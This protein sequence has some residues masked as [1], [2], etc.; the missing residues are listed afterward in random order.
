[1]L[2]IVDGSNPLASLNNSLACRYNADL[3]WVLI[4]AILAGVWAVDLVALHL[5]AA[6]I[7]VV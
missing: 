4:A 6:R 3:I 1:M 5:K 7:A 2:K